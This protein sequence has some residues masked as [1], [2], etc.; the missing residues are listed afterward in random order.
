MTNSETANCKRFDA[1]LNHSPGLSRKG[2]QFT[3][4]HEESHEAKSIT[5]TTGSLT[6]LYGKSHWTTR[7]ITQRVHREKNL[8]NRD[9]RRVTWT[10]AGT[11]RNPT[12][13]S[14]AN[15][16]TAALRSNQ[17]GWSIWRH[18]SSVDHADLGP[19]PNYRTVRLAR[20][21]RVRTQ[22]TR[23]CVSAP[24][25]VRNI[26][27]YLPTVVLPWTT[28]SRTT[29]VYSSIARKSLPETSDCWEWDSKIRS[30]NQEIIC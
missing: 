29:E 7:E 17:F 12:V 21:A 15:Y 4:P 20:G 10:S 27:E 26:G 30:V 25:F 28:C 14:A 11:I 22:G 6:G 3:G 5:E 1:V 23:S 16:T 19:P 9:S 24:P 13:R 2:E 18:A 8:M